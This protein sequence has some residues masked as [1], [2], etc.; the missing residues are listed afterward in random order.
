MV[1]HA[2]SDATG[3]SGGSA[4]TIARL[5]FPQVGGVSILDLL[6]PRF[7]DETDIGGTACYSITAQLPKG[8]ERELLIE[9]GALLLRKVIGLR[10]A[11]RS[12]G[13][14]KNIC[15][16]EALETKLFAA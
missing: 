8:G 10:E 13:I 12:E 5:L 11:A 7:G 9:K 16:N 15:V 3:I 6:N 2:V 4:H 1:F 14:R